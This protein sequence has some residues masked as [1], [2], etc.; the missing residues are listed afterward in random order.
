[1][2]RFCSWGCVLSPFIFAAIF[3]AGSFWMDHIWYENNKESFCPSNLKQIALAISM[4]SQDYDNKL[5]LAISSDETV[6]W[7]NALQPYIKSYPLFQCPIENNPL[8]KTPQPNRPG[9]TDY[10]MNSNVA[11]LEDKKVI[12]PEQLIILGDGDGG[13]PQSTAS[14]AINHIP[15]SWLKL[16]GSPAVRHRSGANYAFADGHVKWLEPDRVSQL[17]SSE[18]HAVFTFMNR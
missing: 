6:G 2:K 7:A 17:P 4:Y 11:G 18:K 15:I 1:M 13:S 10:W 16:V 5:P 8:Q 14:Y 3:Y 9:F 12:S